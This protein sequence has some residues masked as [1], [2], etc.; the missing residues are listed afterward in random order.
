LYWWK[1]TNPDL[2]YFFDFDGQKI[3]T[4]RINKNTNNP[5]FQLNST[6]I[7]FKDAFFNEFGSNNGNELHSILANK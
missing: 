4:D 1:K 7:D 5:S 6:P 2:Y 3:Y